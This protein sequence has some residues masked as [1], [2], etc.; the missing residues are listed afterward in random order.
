MG[1]PAIFLIIF[2]LLLLAEAAIFAMRPSGLAQ[3]ASRPRPAAS[4]DESVQRV[5][6]L[7]A[8]EREGYNPSCVTE[9]LTHGSKAPRAI[10]LVH[11][12]TNC[13]Q[14]FVPL[15]RQFYE[16]GD[17]VLIARLPRQGR[18]DRMTAEHGGLL[19]AELAAYADEVVDIAVGLGE[20]ITMAGLSGGGITTAWAAQH[21]VELDRAV[22]IAPAFGYKQIPASLTVGAMNTALLLLPNIF[23]WWDPKKREKSGPPHTYPRYSSRAVMN[24]LR[25][26]FATRAHAARRPPAARSIVVVTNANDDKVDN[27]AALRMVQVWRASGATDVTHYE[28]PAE[29]KLHHD[30][31]DPDEPDAHPELVYPKLVELMD[32]G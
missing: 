18:A 26:G 4:Y 5:A 10:V 1:W 22:L 12:Y 30:L 15:G 24:I 17:N 23:L 31:I 28:F 3:I 29:L 8:Q 19:A 25:L 14:Q 21:R 32:G 27:A 7:Q 2:L 16:R 13:P 20:H 6:A 9:L 11:G